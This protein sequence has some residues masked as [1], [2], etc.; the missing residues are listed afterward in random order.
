MQKSQGKETEDDQS[1]DE[2]VETCLICCNPIVFHSIGS[3]NHKQ[4]CS[5]CSI[6]LRE[7]YKDKECV[8]CKVIIC[9]QLI[10]TSYSEST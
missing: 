1:D 6:R 10:F 7:L 3:C 4:L 9:F 5:M 8:I 2:E